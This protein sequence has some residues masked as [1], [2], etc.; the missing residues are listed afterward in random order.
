MAVHDTMDFKRRLRST[1]PNFETEE[2]FD[3]TIP[4]SEASVHMNEKTL[5]QKNSHSK[6]S[7][8]NNF[9][10]HCYKKAKSHR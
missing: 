4:H 3:P 9:I 8:V 7:E 2:T 5:Y 1:I 10:E 6:K